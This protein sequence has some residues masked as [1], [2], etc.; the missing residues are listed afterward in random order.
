MNWRPWRAMLAAP[1]PAVAICECRG[2]AED[3][4]MR[5]QATRALVLVLAT[6]LAAGGCASQHSASSSKP[7]IN[8]SS[9]DLTPDQR[10]IREAANSVTPVEQQGGDDFDW[11]TDNPEI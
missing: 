8:T 10:T 5:K 9:P 4:R 1:L 7:T 11:F 6:A 3:P 2:S